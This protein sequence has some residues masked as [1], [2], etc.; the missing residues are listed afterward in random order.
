MKKPRVLIVDDDDLFIQKLSVILEPLSNEIYKSRSAENALYYISTFKPDY[1]FIDNILP[2][3]KGNDVI[4]QFKEFHPGMKIILFSG[5]FDM[6]EVSSAIQNQTD[7]ILEKG[8][9][10]NN[11]VTQILN[12]N[13]FSEGKN[14]FLDRILVKLNQLKDQSKYNIAILEDDELF[15]LKL[16][17]TIQNHQINENDIVSYSSKKSFLKG[18]DKNIPDIV[19]MDYF[20]PD[21]NSMNLLE[22]IK[23]KRANT[24]IIFISSQEDAHIAMSLK[25]KKCDGYIIKNENWESK[26]ID[27]I[28]QLTV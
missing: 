2:K 12:D 11:T 10:D 4:K 20:L 19:F 23:E 5:R 7:F 21:G 9:I 13:K 6:N 15:Q 25:N 26:L 1:L 22:K 24:K 18:I 17:K 27:Y 3:L 28:H 14:S 16:K 8:S